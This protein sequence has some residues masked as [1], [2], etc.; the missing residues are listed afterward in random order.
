MPPAAPVALVTGAG[1]RLGQAIAVALGARGMRVAVHHNRSGADETCRLIRERGGEAVP[2]PADLADPDAPDALVAAV[3]ARFGTIDVLV[4]S[5]A[6]MERTPIGEVTPAQW[7]AMFALNLRAP[8]F[9]AQ[10]AH[11]VMAERGGVIVNM[12]DLAAFET[13]PAYVPHGISKAGVVQ[14]TRALARALAPG[15]RVN[16]VAPGAVMLPD[17]WNAAAGERLRS[18]TPLQRL[19]APDD[20]VQAVLY[21]VDAGYVTGETIVVDGGRHVRR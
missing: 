3:A 9:L 16:A 7:D 21:L 12:A 1:R 6:I 20:V 18:T 17:A 8:F 13:W 14:M 19:G 5:A 15:V 11:R 4:N 10:A 2:F